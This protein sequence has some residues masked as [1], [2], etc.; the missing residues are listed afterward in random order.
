L[1]RIAIVTDSNSGITQKAAEELGVYVVPMPFTID[2]KEYFEDISL[3]QE[4]FYEKLL[5][6]AEI[7]TSQPSPEAVLKLW[8]ELLKEYEEI[9]YI[10]MSSGLS[11]A[12]QTA[13]ALAMDF[14]G[15]V[16]VIDNQRISVPMKHSVL[17]AQALAEEGK[18]GAKIKRILEEDKMQSSIYITIATLKYLAKGGRLT[19]AAAAIGTM[20]RL[21]PVLTIQGEKLD[22]YAKART[23][24]QAKTLMLNALKND[25]ETRFGGVHND[26]KIYLQMAHTA[27]EE[28]ILEFR[29]EL[30]AFLPGYD[31]H[32]D[33]LS[34]SVACHIGPGSLAIAC[35]K[36]M[37]V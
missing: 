22:A 12:C 19:P 13:A 2:G 4:A 24:T 1:S 6:D 3:T 33:P 20:L 27:N 30:T 31:I 26:G 17:D 8:K 14:E 23:I 28:A 16:Q 25:I 34:L 11:G 36:K 32:I 7:S 35:C 37:E 18:N 21:K 29:E 10:P 5:Q 9:V 15:R